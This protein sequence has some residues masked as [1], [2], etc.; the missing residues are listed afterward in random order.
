MQKYLEDRGEVTFEKIFSQKLGE[1]GSG[2]A[3][4]QASLLA[5]TPVSPAVLPTLWRFGLPSTQGGA[6]SETPGF[7]P[8]LCDPVCLLAPA[9]RPREPRGGGGGPES[10]RAAREVPPLGFL[11]L[12]VAASPWR[13]RSCSGPLVELTGRGGALPVAPA[14]LWLAPPHPMGPLCKQPAWRWP[15]IPP[16][17]GV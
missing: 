15:S 13:G 17:A 12:R 8:S 1:Y 2:S 16:P 9:H 6:A 10:S 5:P 7:A 11:F 14:E 4:H 3:S